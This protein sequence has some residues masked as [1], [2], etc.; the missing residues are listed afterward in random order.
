MSNHCQRREIKSVR[1]AASIRAVFCFV[2]NNY[3]LIISLVGSSESSC[4]TVTE[5][6]DFFSMNFLIHFRAHFNNIILVIW[7]SP[8][9]FHMHT[10]CE[11]CSVPSSLVL[12]FQVSAC[13]CFYF[14]PLFS[15]GNFLCVNE[16][17]HE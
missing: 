14:F 6:R 15:T 11:Q 4:L 2:L 1:K 13:V 7:L 5:G 3:H 8:T 10:V 9:D 16:S 12:V 17:N